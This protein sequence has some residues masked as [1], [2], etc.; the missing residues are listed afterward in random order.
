MNGSLLYL[1]WVASGQAGQQDR[2]KC[3]HEAEES[4]ENRDSTYLTPVMWMT[5]D[6]QDLP[7]GSCTH[8]SGPGLEKMKEE[9][10]EEAQLEHWS[11]PTR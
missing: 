9:I 5:T 10:Q 11:L 3:M 7:W 1:G 8:T 4:G 2:H 6:A